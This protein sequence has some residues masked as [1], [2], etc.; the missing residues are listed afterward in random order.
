MKYVQAVAL[1][2][3]LCFL[4]AGCASSRNGGKL[5]RAGEVTQL[6]ESA[7]VLPDHTYYYTGPRAKPDAIIAIDNRFS[8]QGKYWTR[9]DDPAGQLKEWNRY[10][11]N[12]HRVPYEQE[13]PKSVSPFYHGAR[14]MT[15]DGREAGLWYSRHGHTVVR[16][17]EP[18]T[19]AVHA[20]TAPVERKRPLPPG[21]R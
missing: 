21:K 18:G 12:R 13:G 20:P 15:P 11:D 6:I 17:P 10:I 14:I 4:S 9:V 7:T 5:V 1:L 19:I 3:V 8:L 2:L 16:F